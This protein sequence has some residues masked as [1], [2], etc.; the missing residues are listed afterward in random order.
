MELSEYQVQA[1]TTA[2]Y[3][4]QQ[5]FL[6]LAYVLL[7]LNGESGEA[8]E[9][10]K[11]MWRDD[12][13]D[14]LQNILAAVDRFERRDITIESLRQEISNAFIVPLTDERRASLIKEMGDV[15]WYLSQVATEIDISLDEVAQLNIEKLASRRER[16]VLHGSG[17][18]R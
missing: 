10:V 16:D 6:G 15:L 5:G 12:S 7:G 13:A 14:I 9:Q 18:D 11:K 17:D 2:R 1:A 4:G 3:P 8:A